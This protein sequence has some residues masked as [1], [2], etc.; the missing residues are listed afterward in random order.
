MAAQTITVKATGDDGKVVLWERDDAH[1]GGECYVV[2]DGR[3]Y[4]VGRTSEVARHLREGDLE[5]V[6]KGGKGGK[7]ASADA[8]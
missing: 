3:E 5:E 7:A 1:P 2:A 4:A 6:G 8:E